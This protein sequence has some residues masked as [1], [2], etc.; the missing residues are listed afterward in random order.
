MVARSRRRSPAWA[1]DG[2]AATCSSDRSPG[3]SQR[4]GLE[5]LASLTRIGASVIREPVDPDV[6][7]GSAT[8]VIRDGGGFRQVSAWRLRGERLIPVA[9]AGPAGVRLVDL[10]R[11]TGITAAALAATGSVSTADPAARAA[12]SGVAGREIAA[13][14]PG[15]DGPWGVLLA[16]TA[17]VSRQAAIS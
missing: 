10:P 6:L 2:R 1:G 11:S 9:M 14:I 5:V 12:R 8:R 3:P 15:S 16:V 17:S 7:L 13:A 4:S